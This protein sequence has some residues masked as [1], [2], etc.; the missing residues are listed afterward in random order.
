MLSNKEKVYLLKL[1]RRSIE[2]VFEGKKG[3]LTYSIGN[4]SI[5]GNGFLRA[6]PEYDFFLD[7]NSKKNISVRADNRYDVAKMAKKLG[8]SKN[9]MKDIEKLLGGG[10]MPSFPKR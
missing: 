9:S 3:I 4:A 2:R 6:N 10:K 5:I 1:A 8:G 7:I